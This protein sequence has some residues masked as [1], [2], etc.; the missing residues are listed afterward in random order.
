MDLSVVEN[1]LSISSAFPI[2]IQHFAVID[3]ETNSLDP[4][5]GDILSI[6]VIVF[7][8]MLIDYKCV[9]ARVCEHFEF[10]NNDP[11][12]H[13]TPQ[14]YIINKIADQDRIRCGEPILTILAKVKHIIR[15]C[16]EVY[17]YN[18]DF[19]RRF[20]EKYN[21]HFFDNLDYREI[22]VNK[23]ES[24]VNALQRMLYKYSN[25]GAISKAVRLQKHLHS[26]LDD[27][28]VEGVLVLYYIK[29][30]QVQPFIYDCDSYYPKFAAGKLKNC[31]IRV[32]LIMD[33]NEV[34]NCGFNNTIEHRQY[35]QQWIY[36]N[37]TNMI[38]MLIR[39]Y[40]WSLF[41]N[42]NTKTIAFITHYMHLTIQELHLSDLSLADLKNISTDEM[43]R[44]FLSFPELEAR[45]GTNIVTNLQHTKYNLL[46][47]EVRSIMLRF[48]RLSDN[49]KTGEGKD[50][51][52]NKMKAIVITFLVAIY[53]PEQAKEMLIM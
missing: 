3:T 48:S 44:I 41:E 17:A 13:N 4:K 50:N 2:R 7:E 45:I 47:E 12:I 8:L 35:M 39:F 27:V 46:P 9:G 32:A 21:P 16:S 1:P 23:Y 18:K 29:G 11:S 42:G 38:E 5:Y 36:D 40:H 49:M 37:A 33:P 25:N 19:D 22:S 31:D 24:V 43:F 34:Y 53:G 30:Y 26:A 52:Y 15:N 6:A 10:F 20:I 28:M 14:C 51:Y